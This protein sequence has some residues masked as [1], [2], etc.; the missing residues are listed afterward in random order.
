LSAESKRSLYGNLNRYKKRS[1]VLAI[2]SQAPI[3]PMY[4]R[5]SRECLPVGERKIRPGKIIIRY[6]PAIS[7]KGLTYEDRDM[8]LEKI[9]TI[10]EAEHNYWNHA[11]KSLA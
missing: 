4:V 11:A 9:R 3:H 10:G 6:L 1:V 5:G 7:T 8:L 2:E